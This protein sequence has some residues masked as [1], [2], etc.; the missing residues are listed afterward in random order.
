[1]SIKG[2]QIT[3]K[4]L[5]QHLQSAT[6]FISGPLLQ[7]LQ[8]MAWDILK[9][10]APTQFIAEQN[11]SKFLLDQKGDCKNVLIPDQS[12]YLNLMKEIRYQI[13]PFLFIC[14]FDTS[15]CYTYIVHYLLH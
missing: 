1:M 15:S 9:K 12:K 13:S 4:V 11:K 3:G 7:G 6:F 5:I 8:E 2:I 10:L 14:S